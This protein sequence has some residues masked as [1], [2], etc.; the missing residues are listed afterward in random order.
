MINEGVSHRELLNDSEPGQAK[1]STA[2]GSN[3]RLKTEKGV[4]SSLVVASKI[5]KMLPLMEKT[6]M[7]IERMANSF[8]HE[9]P[10]MIR[11][12]T[13]F[14]ELSN[15][16]GL[17]QDQV[18]SAAMILMKE[19]RLSQLYY[20]LPTNEEKLCFFVRLIN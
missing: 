14:E 12:G 18:M 5:E 11:K 4:S 10:L 6:S 9:D 15:V 3:K 20:Q 16:E 7:N 17:S 19:D 2:G 1:K 13:L 8:F